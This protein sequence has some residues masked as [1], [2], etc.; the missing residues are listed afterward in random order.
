MPIVETSTVRALNTQ[1]LSKST[2][3][4]HRNSA[5]HKYVS[6]IAE[7]ELFWNLNE[8][9]GKRHTFKRFPKATRILSFANSWLHYKTQNMATFAL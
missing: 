8:S 2:H 7:I 3:K 6:D 4:Y 5:A 1:T 9:L